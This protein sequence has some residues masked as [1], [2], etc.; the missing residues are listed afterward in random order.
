ME[1]ATV[2]HVDNISVLTLKKSEF[3]VRC[4]FAEKIKDRPTSDTVIRH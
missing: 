2:T 4:H 3:V 1:K